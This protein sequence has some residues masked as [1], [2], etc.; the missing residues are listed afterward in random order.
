MAAQP[1]ERKLNSKRRS[2]N[3]APYQKS[4]VTKKFA[5]SPVLGLKEAKDL[6]C[7]LAARSKERR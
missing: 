5:A 7:S 6:F 1:E 3:A 4:N 2:E